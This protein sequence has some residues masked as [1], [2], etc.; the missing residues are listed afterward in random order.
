MKPIVKI[1]G[2]C[3]DAVRLKYDPQAN[4]KPFYDY[5][6]IS[7]MVKMLGEKNDS[8][9]HK[10]KKYPLIWLIQDF[11]EDY[12]IVAGRICD[13][14]LR[15]V[16]ITHTEKD[17]YAS[18]RYNTTIEPILYPILKL[19][20]DA[21]EK[22]QNNNQGRFKFKKTDK[23]HWGKSGIYGNEGYIDNDYIDAIELTIN[24]KIIQNCN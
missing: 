10:F 16:I 2:E 1:I 18:E 4:E 22:H 13:V 15:L 3:V 9:T 6:P 20:I 17:I 23:L 19:L 24:L 5:G 21:I 12:G 11:D 14:S 8:K 7:D